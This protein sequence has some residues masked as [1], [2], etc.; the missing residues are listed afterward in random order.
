M[1][2]VSLMVIWKVTGLVAFGDTGTNPE[3]NPTW[4]VVDVTASD[5]HGAVK[6]D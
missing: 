2:V 6:Y 1:G 3:S 4:P 5:T